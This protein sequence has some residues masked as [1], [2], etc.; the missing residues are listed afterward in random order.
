MGRLRG[1]KSETGTSM[2]VSASE[3]HIYII[4]YVTNFNVHRGAY[5][6]S[7]IVQACC[8]HIS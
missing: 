8:K 7:N 5:I 1:I 6:S 4:R 2:G 3:G